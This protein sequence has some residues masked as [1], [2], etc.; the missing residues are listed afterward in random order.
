MHSFVTVNPQTADPVYDL[1]TAAAVLAATGITVTDAQVT[2]ASKLIADI[3]GRVFALQ[4]VTETFRIRWH[5]KCEALSLSRF[6]IVGDIL[7]DVNDVSLVDTSYEVNAE[8]GQVW[9]LWSHWH[10]VVSVTYSGGYN[11]PTDAPEGLAQA[12]IQILK[13]RSFMAS[14]D[15]SIR[16]V[17][18]GENRVSYFDQRSG[19]G[20][21]AISAA[22]EGLIAPY[23][24]LAV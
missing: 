12:C 9:R 4:N 22:V 17:W 13:E 5:E 6:P 10:G 15:I 24:H 18:A 16:D 3:C 2:A 23:K 19:G 11:L 1:T 14:R 8:S 7:I 20:N 21:N